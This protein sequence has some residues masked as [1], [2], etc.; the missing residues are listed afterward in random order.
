[1]QLPELV[2]RLA[3]MPHFVVRLLHESQQRE[4]LQLRAAQR[5]MELPDDTVR[6]LQRRYARDMV[7]MQGLLDRLDAASLEEQRRL[8]VPF[9]RQV[10]GDHS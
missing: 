5:G 4:A 1:M 3:S 7:T 2:S 10:T 9:I 8:T 6:Y